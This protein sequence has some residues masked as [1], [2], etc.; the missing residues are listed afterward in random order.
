MGYGTVL[1]TATT[2]LDAEDQYRN[3]GRNLI[4]QTSHSV[5]GAA[6]TFV[7]EAADHFVYLH[8][9]QSDALIGRFKKQ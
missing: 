3:H 8:K 7:G 5:L 1:P 4:L 2:G 9:L 6:K